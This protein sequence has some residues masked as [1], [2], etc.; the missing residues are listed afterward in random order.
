MTT[1][2]LYD[3][4]LNG[5]MTAIFTIYD[6][7]IKLPIIALDSREQNH[8]FEGTELVITDPDKA[9]R[10]WKRFNSLCEHQ[11]AHQV[12]CAFLSEIIGI[13]NTIYEYLKMT[14]TAQKA[15]GGDSAN[16]T[17]LK[18]TQ[19]AKMVHHEKHRMEG[20]VRFHLMDEET[21]Y[22]HIEPDFNILP[23][24]VSHFKNQYT[25]QKW[26]IYDLK[27][28]FGISYDLETVQEVQID[29]K[30]ARGQGGVLP[31]R[32]SENS[33]DVA[34][35]GG[36]HNSTGLR[37]NSNEINYKDLWNQYFNSAYVKSRKSLK[38]HLE[39]VPK[40]SWRYLSEKYKEQ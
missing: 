21:Y 23:L 35:S 20:L 7:K 26:I 8:L 25:D 1:T 4:S 17:V 18:I 40:R 39:Y 13:E 9:Q 36:F 15:P 19:A 14:F 11:N 30:K 3:G 34:S 29:F 37:I 33:S 16:S 28:N 38:L 22:A 24:L 32:V 6:R 12:Y 31:T 2:L 5:L 27:R 10:V